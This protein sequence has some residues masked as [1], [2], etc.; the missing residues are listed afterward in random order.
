MPRKKISLSSEKTAPFQHHPRTQAK[1]HRFY[2]IQFPTIELGIPHHNAKKY[3]FRYRVKKPLNFITA[4]ER[5]QQH[6]GFAKFGSQRS[7]R[8]TP[9]PNTKK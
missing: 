3:F 1:M 9:H 2:K 6:P 5:K 8:G 4:L 7:S